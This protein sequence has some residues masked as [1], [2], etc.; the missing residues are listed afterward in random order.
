LITQKKLCDLVLG[1][2]SLLLVWFSSPGL[3][4][5]DTQLSLGEIKDRQWLSE[6]YRDHPLVGKIW[7]SSTAQFVDEATLRDALRHQGVLLLGEK[8][9]NPDHHALR[10][11]LLRPLLND[12]ATA[13]VALEMMASSQQAVLDDP[14]TLITANSDALQAQL[15]WD[16]HGWPWSIY[17]PLLLSIIQAGVPMRA[18]NLERTDAARVYRGDSDALS[19]RQPLS[20]NQLAQLHVDI[21]ISHCGMLPEGQL[22]NMVRVQ[23]ARDQHMADSLMHEAKDPAALGRRVLI[24]G[25]YHIRHDL[26][27]PNYLPDHAPEPVAVAFLEVDAAKITPIDYLPQISPQVTYDFI[28]FTPAVRIDDYCADIRQSD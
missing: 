3:A 16:T 11:S 28:W 26:G 17:E 21:D 24:A 10:L 7:H 23:Q 25:N 5:T 18:A 9:D 4:Q 6:H 27:V 20:E 14:D 1:F 8:H 12:G 19:V 13:L 22:A 2:A 15:Q